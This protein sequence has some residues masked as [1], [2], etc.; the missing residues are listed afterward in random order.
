MSPIQ[1]PKIKGTLIL[2]LLN[3]LHGNNVIFP[4]YLFHLFHCIVNQEMF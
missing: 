1:D 3:A 2:L 4:G